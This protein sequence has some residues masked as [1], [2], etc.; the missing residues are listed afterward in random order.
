MHVVLAT[1]MNNGFGR[2]RRDMENS[3]ARDFGCLEAVKIEKRKEIQQIEE[4]QAHCMDVIWDATNFLNYD[5]K[6]PVWL[7]HL[8]MGH[9]KK[10]ANKWL[11]ERIR[12]A[13]RNLSLQQKRGVEL[14]E[15]REAEHAAGQDWMTDRPE[16]EWSDAED[17][18]DIEDGV[19]LADN[20]R[21][22][23]PSRNWPQMESDTSERNLE[24]LA[25]E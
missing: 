21:M 9:N 12:S 10:H 8:R 25:N 14:L 6:D 11:S 20:N 13:L 17:D 2:I 4:M 1:T 22:W 18:F 16:M 23:R 24:R 3:L 15:Q 5:W 7:G 19:P